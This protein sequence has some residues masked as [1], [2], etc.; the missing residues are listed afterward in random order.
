MAA[1]LARPWSLGKLAA[2]S[3]VLNLTY[4][5][6]ELKP[7]ISWPYFFH[8]WQLTGK[9]EQDKL[10]AEAEH[11]L[12]SLNE[13]YAAH[14]LCALCEAGSD[15]DD[16]LID[17]VRLP[18][19]RQQRP[20]GDGEPCL[21]LADFVRPV[22]QDG[23][24]DTVG[25]FATTV[26][27]GLETDFHGDAYEKMMVQLLADRLAEAAAERLHE[28]VRTTYWGYAPNER[29]SIADMLV[30]KY[31]GIRPAVGY[32]SLPDTSIN[33][34]LSDIIDFGKIDIRLTENGA[35]RPHASV[36]GLMIA[37]PSAHYFAVGRIGED[38]LADYARRRGVPKE[39]ARRFLAANIE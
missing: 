5:V 13:R 20:H 32:P 29:L 3:H 14:A 11:E 21:A 6:A 8:A 15:G 36:S 9:G 28:Q 39:T 10:Q 37:H 33:F 34:I 7:Y 31:Q 19:L 27:W 16:I 30:G 23:F 38:Q 4:S 25:V 1:S 17:G 18:T 22:E 24:H 26:D 2:M 12:D 35:M